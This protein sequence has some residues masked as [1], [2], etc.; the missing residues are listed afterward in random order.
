MYE[1]SSLKIIRRNTI[2][3]SK[4]L[5]SCSE[6]PCLGKSIAAAQAQLFALLP[7]D[8]RLP[9]DIGDN[10]MFIS[11]ITD[12]SSFKYMLGNHISGLLSHTGW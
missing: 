10:I 7:G 9:P 12:N 2:S 8:E 3:L 11:K 6:T 4:A 5:F 1:T